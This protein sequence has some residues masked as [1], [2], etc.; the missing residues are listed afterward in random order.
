MT[1]DLFGAEVST[2]AAASY[3]GG[4][5]GRFHETGIEDDHRLNH[6]RYPV[7]RWQDGAFRKV[8][9]PALNALNE[10]LR[11]DFIAD[12]EAGVG[13]INRVVRGFEVDFEITLP[14]VAF[15]RR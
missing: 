4:L 14:H 13:R 1:L 5:K 10:R 8:G 3:T 11:D 6:A 7:L 12:V 15:N 9:A 2:N